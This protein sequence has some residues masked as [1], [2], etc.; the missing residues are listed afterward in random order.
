MPSPQAVAAAPE[1]AAQLLR[2]ASHG[3][4]PHESIAAVVASAR[5]TFGVPMTHE[6]QLTLH[7]IVDSIERETRLLDALDKQLGEA[8]PDGPRDGSHGRR[9]GARMRVRN[10]GPH[11]A[12]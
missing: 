1:E 5:D 2:K 7:A 10:C 8:V 11:R 6:E 12:A 9:G 3:A 4:L